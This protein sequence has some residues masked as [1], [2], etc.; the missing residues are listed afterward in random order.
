MSRLDTN[1]LKQIYKFIHPRKHHPFLSGPIPV[2]WRYFDCQVLSLTNQFCEA[3][4]QPGGEGYHYQLSW[5][6][7][8]RPRRILSLTWIPSDMVAL[9]LLSQDIFARNH[10][11]NKV[12]KWSLILTI[13]HPLQLGRIL[14]S[15]SPCSSM[16][17]VVLEWL[18]LVQWLHKH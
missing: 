17:P 10:L 11:I 4:T 5:W 16:W 13:I 3:E 6:S 8:A 12:S 2:G 7:L 9:Y 15:P 18:T 14:L 1:T